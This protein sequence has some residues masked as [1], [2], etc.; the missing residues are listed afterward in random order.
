MRKIWAVIA[1]VAAS[2]FPAARAHTSLESSYPAEKQKVYVPLHRITLIFS[3][4]ADALYSA[5]RLENAKGEL[6]VQAVQ[7]K[8]AREI[9]MKTPALDPGRYFIRYRVLSMDG[10][11]V[12]GKVAFEIFGVEA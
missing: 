8:A 4:K 5:V 3:G 2:S 11:I 10:D 7:K 6:V 1:A 12:E 9:D